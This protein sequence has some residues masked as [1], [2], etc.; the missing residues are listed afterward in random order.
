MTRPRSGAGSRTRLRP[1]SHACPARWDISSGRD[2]DGRYRYGTTM[3]HTAREL[4]A[5]AAAGGE[6]LETVA[7]AVLERLAKLTG[8]SSTYLAE[9]RLRGDEQVI[10]F[11]QHSRLI[12]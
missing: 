9:T 12:F 2:R 7:R 8:L 5:E 3:P 4:R 10:L 1:R 6:D 11:F